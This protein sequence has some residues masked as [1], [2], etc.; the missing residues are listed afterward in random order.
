MRISRS[1]I[2]LLI[3]GQTLI[4][5]SEMEESSL[6]PAIEQ[7]T[8]VEG[9]L[10]ASVDEHHAFTSG[11]QTYKTYLKFSALDP[12]TFSPQHLLQ[13]LSTFTP[14]LHSHLVAEISTLLSLSKCRYLTPSI[15]I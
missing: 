8:G 15:S 13:I 11:L 14:A 4:C 10:S 5:G 3:T 2:S 1:L 6:F 9:L 7:I 12:S